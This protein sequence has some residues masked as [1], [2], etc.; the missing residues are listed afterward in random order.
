MNFK[1]MVRRNCL[2]EASH[3]DEVEVGEMTNR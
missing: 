1:V 2:S 3:L